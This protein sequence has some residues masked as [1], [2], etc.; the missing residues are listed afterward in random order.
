[1]TLE[2]EATQTLGPILDRPQQESVDDL[3]HN[4]VIPTLVPT[5]AGDFANLATRRWT[6]PASLIQHQPINSIIATGIYKSR[7]FSLIFQFL[8][9]YY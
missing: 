1:M 8:I 3:F 7:R 6:T 4:L 5:G 9:I 2:E